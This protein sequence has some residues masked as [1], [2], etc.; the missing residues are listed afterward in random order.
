MTREQIHALMATG[1][2]PEGNVPEKLVET[3]ISWVLLCNAKVYKIKKAV[4]LSFLDF[5]SL[6]K[7]KHFVE[8]ELHLNQRLAPAVYLRALSVVLHD[9]RYCI[10]G[11]EGELVD[12]ALEMKRLDNSLEMDVLLAQGKVDRTDIDR[13]LQVLIPFHRNAEIIRGHIS[14]AAILSDFADVAQI[15]DFCTASLGAA[16]GAD[17]IASIAWV[18]AFLTEQAPLIEQRDREGFTRDVHG[19]LH[20]GNIFLTDP[21]TLFDCIEFSPHFRRIDLLNEL[22]FFTMELEFAGHPELSAHLMERYNSAFPVMRNAADRKLYLFY[23]LY[24][25]NVRMKVNAIRVQQTKEAG[26]RGKR[27]ELFT[28]YFELYRGYWKVLAG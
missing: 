17:L 25:A 9:G 18:K 16:Q 3:H 1:E 14:A 10:G 21:P 11:T 7:R 12:H 24:R 8:Q 20:A 27:M 23:K 28:R 2:F 5:S 19:D 22:A 4:K 15:R 13:V 26:E 6:E